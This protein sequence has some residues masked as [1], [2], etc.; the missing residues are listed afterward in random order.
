[1]TTDELAKTIHVAAVNETEIIS[2]TV[3]HR[4]P[5]TATKIA[6]EV[7]NIFSDEVVK[8]YNIE[9]VT[10]LDS[11]EIPRKAANMSFL[12]QFGI[13]LVA[14]ILLGSAIA[15]VLAYFDTTIKS[16]DQI[17]ELTGL[18]ILGRVPNYHGKRKGR[19]K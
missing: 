19:R 16:V 7:A 1:M 11:A 17:E 13:A 15:F 8:I 12:K 2:I 18:P 4:N 9:N 6:N 5:Q 3:S 10:I 14:G